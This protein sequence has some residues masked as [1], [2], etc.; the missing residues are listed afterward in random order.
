MIERIDDVPITIEDCAT[1]SRASSAIL[2]VK[3]PIKDPYVLEVSSC[4]LDRP[5]TKTK[6]FKKYISHAVTLQ[7]HELIENR[8]NFIGDLLD[9]NDHEITLQVQATDTD[10]EEKTI[11]IPYDSIKSARLYVDFSKL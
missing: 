7:T 6:D 10:T 4:G 2:D 9:A 5:L 3:D 11:S 1:V 8:K